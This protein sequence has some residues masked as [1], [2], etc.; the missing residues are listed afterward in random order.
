MSLLAL[1]GARPLRF[2]FPVLSHRQKVRGRHGRSG[3]S[4]AANDGAAEYL[5]AQA[6]VQKAAY[7]HGFVS[8]D[9]SMLPRSI[10]R[11]WWG[12]EVRDALTPW[13]PD[14]AGDLVLDR[15]RVQAYV[16]EKDEALVATRSL[17]AQIG[18]RDATVEGCRRMSRRSSGISRSGS[19]AWDCAPRS[20][21][22]AAG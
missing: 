8:A 2:A 19:R 7:T 17:I 4:R 1:P 21:S 3:E 22:I 6:I 5:D 9:N 20:V 15:E 10:G 18:G 13:A 12:M 14:R 16:S 11:A